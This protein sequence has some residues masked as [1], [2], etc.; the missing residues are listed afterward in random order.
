MPYSRF[1]EQ[2]IASATTFTVIIAFGG[3]SAQGDF[4][5]YP[6]N[7]DILIHMETRQTVNSWRA[8]KEACEVLNSQLAVLR[9]PGLWNWV[10]NELNKVEGLSRRRLRKTYHF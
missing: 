6:Q 10:W 2:C 8:A 3:V 4:R 1:H 9:N 5:P 7:P